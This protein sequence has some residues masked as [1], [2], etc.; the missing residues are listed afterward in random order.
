MARSYQQEEIPA[1]SAERV[2]HDLHEGRCA[3]GREHV[4]ERPP[5][6]PGAPLSIGPR[7][8]ALAVYLVVFQHMRSSGAGT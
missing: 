6:V 3:C 4:A 2:Q 5:G 1:A 7:L 8:R